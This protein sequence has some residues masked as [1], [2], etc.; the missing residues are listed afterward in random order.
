MRLPDIHERTKDIREESARK[1]KVSHVIEEEKIQEK[2]KKKAKGKMHKSI[3]MKNIMPKKLFEID[4][5]KFNYFSQRQIKP[6]VKGKKS[7][8]PISKKIKIKPKRFSYRIT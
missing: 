3:S 1:K 7:A 8:S 2:K 6:I 5:E 4:K